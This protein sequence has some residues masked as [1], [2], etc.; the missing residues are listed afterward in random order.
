MT[1]IN[2]CTD[3]A[4]EKQGPIWRKGRRVRSQLSEYL[5]KELME[6]HGE[7]GTPA[8]INQAINQN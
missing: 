8:S 6:S 2:K 3:W 5:F 7:L 4:I 1:D